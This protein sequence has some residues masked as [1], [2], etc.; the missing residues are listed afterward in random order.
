MLRH[1]ISDGECEFP[2]AGCGSPNSYTSYARHNNKD[3]PPVMSPTG[4]SMATGRSE[5]TLSPEL[6]RSPRAKKTR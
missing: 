5:A 1:F 6:Y 2:P 3:L 4:R